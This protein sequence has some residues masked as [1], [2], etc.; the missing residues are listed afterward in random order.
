MIKEDTMAINEWPE[1][2]RPREK[3]RHLGA[4]S[5]SDAELLAIFLRTGIAGKTAID[6][7]REQLERFGSLNSLLSANEADF[8]AGEGLGPAKY[9]QLQA[10]LELSKRYL[11]ESV[12]IK[13]VMNNPNQVKDYLRAHLKNYQHEVFCCLYM[14]T[15]NEIIKFEPLFRGTLDCAAV[16][17]REVAKQ[18]LA[19]AAKSIILV[20]NHPSGCAEPS[21]ADKSITHQIKQAL[22]YLD[23]NVLDHFVVGHN[24][25]YSFAEHGLL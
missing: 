14:N 22:G 11:A 7:A 19:N 3:L 21:Q 25:V 1:M 15:Q 12:E 16:Y 23:I 17:P 20:H 24:D 5:L 2:E 10:V 4:K 13:D 18:A 9:V 6:V 8:C